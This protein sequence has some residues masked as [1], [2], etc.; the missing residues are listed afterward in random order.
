[1]LKHERI[2]YFFEFG[3]FKEAENTMHRIAMMSTGSQP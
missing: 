1:M 2:M 3:F